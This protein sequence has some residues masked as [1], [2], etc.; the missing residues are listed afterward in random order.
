MVTCFRWLLAFNAHLALAIDC[1]QDII[2]L[3]S[4]IFL[5]LSTLVRS[6]SIRRIVLVA[7]AFLICFNSIFQ[8]NAAE[9]PNILFF[10]IDDQ[11]N[12][13]LGCAGH[14]IIKTPNID[15]LA[16]DGVRFE[17]A[18][19]TTSICWVSRATILTGMWSRTH[20][21]QARIDSVSAEAAKTIYPKL[22]Q[23]A[24]YRNGFFGKWHAKM[25]KGFN[26]SQYYDQYEGIS[27][28]PYFKKQANGGMRHET[29]LIGDRAEA[30]LDSQPA[31]KPFCLNLWFN[32]SHA[33][34]SDKRPGI[35]H[36]PWPKAVAGMYEDIEVPAPRLN[37]PKIYASQPDF[38]KNSINRERFFWRWDTAEKYQTNIRAYFRM[39]SGIDGVVGRVMKKLKEKG[40]D[41]NTVV[42]VSADNGYYMGDRGFAGKWSHYEQSIRVPMIIY[43]PRLPADK[44]GR[45]LPQFALNV[46]LPTTF[47]DLAGVDKPKQY[48]GSSLAPL[49]AGDTPTDWRTD[50]LG[51]H[52]LEFDHRIPKWEGVRNQRYIYA[53]YFQ[54]EYEFLH[55]LKADPD[56]LKNLVDDPNYKETL[57]KLR[58]R[59]DEL[60]DQHGGEYKGRPLSPLKK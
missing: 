29:E 46:D 56:Q 12:T 14:P 11:R 44:A 42:I 50:F 13:S 48:Q 5:A 45:V 8:L 55:D 4:R 40:L 33:E 37:D 26:Q 3:F 16:T 35:G 1:S 15:Q 19:V 58:K 23:E 25:P 10:F 7:F 57:A 60:R 43:D 18:F 28:H 21:T 47:L 20:G 39:I 27:R 49:V 38:L 17:N 51:E 34:D 31:D 41:E 2:V 22:L 36:F 24:G 30:F 59:C 52:L 9:R 6:M 54:H 32:A 53:R